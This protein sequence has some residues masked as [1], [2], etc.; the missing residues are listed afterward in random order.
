MSE[1]IQN[2]R[3]GIVGAGANTRARHIPGLQSISGVQVAAVC[4][5]SRSSSEAVAAEFGIPKVVDHWSDLVGDPEIDAIVIGTWPYMHCP[6]TIAA[7]ESGQH[8]LTEARMAMDAA[9]ARRMLAAARRRPDLIAQVV[10][11]PMTLAVDATVRRLIAEGF[12]GDILV[13]EHRQRG[14]FLDRDAPLHWRH[15][16]DLSGTN[17]LMLG[18]YYE[19]IMRWVGEATRVVAMGKTFARMRRDANGVLRSVRVPEHVDV[20]AELACGAQL[21]MQQSAVAALAEG[22]GTYLFGSEGVLRVVDDR[23]FGARRGESELV[24][25]VPPDAE[26]GGWRVEEEFIAAI[27]GEEQITRT[28]FEDGVKYMEFT[29]AVSRSMASGRAIAL[30]LLEDTQGGRR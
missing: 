10:P 4:N 7:L 27:R 22:E 9:E 15:D 13:V 5:R 19:S 11:S 24:E 23:L 12:P 30:P 6:V 25:I 20:V 1:Q 3:V 17:V 8:V 2:L 28:T 29:E 26:R 21:H 14:D 18:I 16:A